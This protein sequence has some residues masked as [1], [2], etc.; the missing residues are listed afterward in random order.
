[1]WLVLLSLPRSA[2]RCEQEPRM[3]LFFFLE[4]CR[5]WDYGIL[6]FLFSFGAWLGE[7]LTLRKPLL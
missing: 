6:L 5:N 2:R 1:M 7:Q 4:G 3:A